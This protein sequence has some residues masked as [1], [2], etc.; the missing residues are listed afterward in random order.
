MK[1]H[2]LI[3]RYSTI[4]SSVKITPTCSCG[5]IGIGHENWK[6]NFLTLVKDQEKSH[7]RE[8]KK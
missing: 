1:N 6:D 2:K 7:L 8:E 4:E 5:W 3:R